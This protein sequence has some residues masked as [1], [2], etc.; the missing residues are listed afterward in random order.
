MSILLIWIGTKKQ[1]FI[2]QEREII[3]EAFG[4]WSIYPCFIVFSFLSQI[5]LA[6]KNQTD[7]TW[8]G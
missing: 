3:D 4:K 2:A 8:F 1:C 7:S 5:S 6:P